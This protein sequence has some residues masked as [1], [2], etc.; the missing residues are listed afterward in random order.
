M[1]H[2]NES[3][4]KVSIYISWPPINSDSLNSNYIVSS[5][6][7][8]KHEMLST[9]NLSITDVAKNYVNSEPFSNS[10]SSLNDQQNL[11]PKL[12]GVRIENPS[13]IICRQININSIRDI[14]CKIIK[15]G[16]DADFEGIF[17]EINLRKKKWLLCCFYNPHKSNIAN[18]LKNICKILDKLSATYENLILLGDFNVEP[19]EE[20][21]AEFLSLGNL[22]NLVKQNTC[23]KNLDTPT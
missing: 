17:V 11:S 3:P 6:S 10:K 2:I 1:K 16:C 9:K 13:R 20:S 15:T 19:E 22:K 18:H 5:K 12:H 8:A 4:A 21:I 23:F 7:F 14:P